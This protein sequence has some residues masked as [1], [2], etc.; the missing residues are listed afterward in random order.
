MYYNLNNYKS[1]KNRLN[2]NIYIHT[3]Y[4]REQRGGLLKHTKLISDYKIGISFFSFWKKRKMLNK[5][6]RKVNPTKVLRSPFKVSPLPDYDMRIYPTPANQLLHRL[7]GSQS[8]WNSATRKG[9]DSSHQY[10]SRVLPQKLAHLGAYH[11]HYPTRLGIW[12]GIPE[13]VPR[14]KCL[15]N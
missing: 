14:A 12:Y 13:T 15:L 11:S 8:I 3:Y 7:T 6:C 5:K 10:S 1:N 2:S 4:V 9:P